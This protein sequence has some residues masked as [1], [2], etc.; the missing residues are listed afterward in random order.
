[1][2]TKN[3]WLVKS[4]PSTYSWEHFVR[5]KSTR[6][7]GVR[8][9]EARNNLRAMKKSDVVLFYHSGDGKEIVGIAKVVAEAY[10]DPSANDGDWSVV[11]LAAEKALAR[12]VSLAALK[13]DKALSQMAVVRKP[14]ISVVPVL[15]DELGRILELAATKL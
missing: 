6:W 7:D 1:M 11:D 12:P 8:N 5:D 13:Q 10:A 14:R 4:E 3:S 15:P 9:F 2:P